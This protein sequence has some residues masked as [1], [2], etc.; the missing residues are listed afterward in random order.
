METIKDR[1]FDMLSKRENAIEGEAG[2][3]EGEE[4]G[5]ME[6]RGKRGSNRTRT[7]KNSL[8]IVGIWRPS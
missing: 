5:G 6:S 3:K 1:L 8:Q 2:T 4:S 7:D